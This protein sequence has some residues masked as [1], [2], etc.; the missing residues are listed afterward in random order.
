LLDEVLAAIQAG[1]SRTL[2]MSGEAGVGKTALLEYLAENARACRLARAGGVQAEMELAFAGLHQLLAPMLGHVQSLPSVQRDALHTALGLSSGPPPNLFLVGL[3]TLSLLSE[4]AQEKPLLCLVDDQQ[5]LDRESAQVLAFVARRLRAEAVGMV[6]AARIVGEDL[7]GLPELGL[8]GLDEADAARLLERSVSGPLDPV[9][10]DRI[11]RETGGN[12]LALLELTRGLTPA[13][14]AGGFGL[15]AVA[16]LSTSIEESFRRQLDALPPETVGFLQL[17]AADPLGDPVLLW[18][19]A[20]HVPVSPESAAPAI[21]A[22][23]LGLG[24]VVRFRHPLVRSAAYRSMSADERRNAH[25][26]LAEA[27]D[28]RTDPDRRAWHRADAAAG[29][30]ER[31]AQELE[32]SASRAQ[33]RGGLAAAAAFLERAGNLTSE[34]GLRARRLVAAAKAKREAGALDAALGLLVVA[35]G[36]PLDAPEAAEATHL[37]GQIAF[38]QRRIGDASRLL[39]EAARRL[40]PFDVAAARDAHLEALGAAFYAYEPER[41]QEAAQAA[42]AAPQL[43]RP[44]PV[45]LVLDALALRFTDGHA[46]AAPVLTRALKSFLALGTGPD[47]ADRWLWLAGSRANDTIALD[48]WDADSWH[49]IAVRQVQFARETGALVHLQFTNALL[50]Y[51]PHPPRGVEQGR[52]GDRGGP[53]DRRGHQKPKDAVH[54]RR[55]GRLPRSGERGIGPDTGGIARGEDCWTR[56]GDQFR[57]LPERGALQRARPPRRRARGCSR[58]LRAR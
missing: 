13:E 9:V 51:L 21:D 6:L 27:T 32:R 49:E 46:A 17:A 4:V 53:R 19:A 2:V 56:K 23:V 20:D 47:E 10:R 15:P 1:E 3:A 43:E 26:A 14:L 5:W 25:R 55:A 30:D 8:G 18:R 57:D 16:S 50:R 24:A 38:D 31:V 7:A 58:V 12:P 33:A 11:V 29:P 42:R 40:E 54:R 41:L 28:P 44:R 48:L 34:P 45:D 39:L 37:R 52:A 36:G 35:E 22:G